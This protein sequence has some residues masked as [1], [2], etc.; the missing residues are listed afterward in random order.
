LERARFEFRRQSGS[1]MSLRR[2]A[3]YA[4]AVVPDHQQVRQGTLRRIAGNAGLTVA[5]FIEP[6]GR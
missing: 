5:E 6:S 1:R 4:R 3:P 2:S